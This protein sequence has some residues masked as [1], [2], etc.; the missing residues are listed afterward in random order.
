MIARDRAAQ[1]FNLENMIQLAT[2]DLSWSLGSARAAL[3]RDTTRFCIVICLET[4]EVV[5]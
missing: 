2:G 1:N 4:Y 3:H 5:I